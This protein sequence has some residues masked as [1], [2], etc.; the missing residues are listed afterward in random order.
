MGLATQATG[1]L[2]LHVALGGAACAALAAHDTVNYSLLDLKWGPQIPK[3]HTMHASM[4][5]LCMRATP[6][7]LPAQGQPRWGP[8][9]GR[10]QQGSW[11]RVRQETALHICCRC[12]T[13]QVA[14][15]GCSGCACAL[16]STCSAADLVGSGCAGC[17]APA[18]EFC[19][20]VA[21]NR[22]IIAITVRACMRACMPPQAG[23][24]L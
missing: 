8:C 18:A 9:M 4:R 13:Q 7:Q 21:S 6:W 19:A 17:A 1:W 22:I 24:A 3:P 14:F 10:V 16:D 15:L 5:P 2:A 11:S 23:P 20:D 12:S